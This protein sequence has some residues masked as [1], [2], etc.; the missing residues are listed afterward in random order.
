MARHSQHRDSQ[1]MDTG[2]VEDA[3]LQHGEPGGLA[4]IAST[5]AAAALTHRHGD[6]IEGKLLFC[7]V[8]WNGK[9]HWM[10]GVGGVA[11]RR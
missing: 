7:H 4:Y 11:S 5:C 10:L 8:G 3:R 2:S 6:P 1:H 9:S